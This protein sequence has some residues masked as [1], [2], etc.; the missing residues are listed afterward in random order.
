M[1][2]YLTS[3]AETCYS[4]ASDCKAQLIVVENDSQLQK[5]LKVSREGE[6]GSRGEGGERERGGSGEG[7]GRREEVGE[8]E[9]RGSGEGAGRGEGGGRGEGECC[10]LLR[11]EHV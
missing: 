11:I 9:G 3:S 4:I 2:I 8:R 1:G 6:G 5:I 7:R 10:R